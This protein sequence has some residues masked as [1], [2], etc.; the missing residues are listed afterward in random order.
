MDQQSTGSNALCTGHV[1]SFNRLLFHQLLWLPALPEPW[2]N[3]DKHPPKSTSASVG[4]SSVTSPGESMGYK[5]PDMHLQKCKTSLGDPLNRNEIQSVSA[6]PFHPKLMIML[7]IQLLRG[8]LPWI[9]QPATLNKLCSISMKM[10]PPPLLPPSLSLTLASFGNST[11][12][13]HPRLCFQRN[14]E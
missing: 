5:C 3:S 8:L 12:T 11:P 9:W 1:I 4:P 2:L 13:L 6:S 7:L 14:P 10:H